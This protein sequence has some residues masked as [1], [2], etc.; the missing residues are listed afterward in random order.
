MIP[1]LYANNQLRPEVAA[2]QGEDS[3][4]LALLQSESGA[5]YIRV[6]EGI[7]SGQVVN[8]GTE[9]H[10]IPNNPMLRLYQGLTP[11]VAYCFSRI[12]DKRLPNNPRFQFSTKVIE[13]YLDQKLLGK[14]GVSTPM[15]RVE[16][17]N[18]LFGEAWKPVKEVTK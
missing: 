4:H 14:N 2:K 15:Q 9:V 18:F 7:I 12:L 6:L 3:Y 10:A 1:Q 13:R 16:D 5:P 8:S 11:N 17:R